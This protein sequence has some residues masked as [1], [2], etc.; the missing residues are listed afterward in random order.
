MKLK[1]ICCEVFTR[2]ACLGAYRSPHTIDLEFTRLNSHVSPNELRAHIQEKIDAAGSDYD[3]V[4]LGFGLCGNST[5]GLRAGSV[6]LVIPRAHDC[7]TIFLGS[8]DRFLEYFRDSLS[9]QWST[10]GYMERGGEDYLRETGVGRQL[11]VDSGYEEFVQKYGDENAKYI[12]E[13]LYPEMESGEFTFITIPEVSNPEYLETFKSRVSEKGRQLRIIEGDLRLID[14]LIN[15]KWDSEA[16]LTVPPG[17]M[18]S[19]IYDHKL[20]MCAE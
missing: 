5:A 11:G 3:A 19:A 7:C 8:R 1:L 14:N 4:L 16:F 12:W 9:A 17:K 18:I 6:P 2:P 10:D 15:G 20:V 13:T